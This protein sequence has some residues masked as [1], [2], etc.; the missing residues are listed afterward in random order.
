MVLPSMLISLEVSFIFC[1]DKFISSLEERDIVVLQ[2]K[3]MAPL[4]EYKDN[5]PA[6]AET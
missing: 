2:D 6:F 1:E 3:S 4:S 5:F